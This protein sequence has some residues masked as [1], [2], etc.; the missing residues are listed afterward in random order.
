MLAGKEKNIPKNNPERLFTH[1]AFSSIRVVLK[2]E[3]HY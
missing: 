2:T 1:V 3:I